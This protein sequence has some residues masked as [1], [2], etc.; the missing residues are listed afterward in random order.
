[1]ELFEAFDDPVAAAENETLESQ[2]HEAQQHQFA[3][4]GD[5]EPFEVLQHAVHD[6]DTGS[7]AA[8]DNRRGSKLRCVA[9]S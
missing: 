5:V 2:M 8:D 4:V 3:E 7:I 1:M 9:Q 6:S